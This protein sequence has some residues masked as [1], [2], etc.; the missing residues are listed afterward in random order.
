MAGRH[1]KT[2]RR[3]RHRKPPSPARIAL[4]TGT[5]LAVIVAAVVVFTHTDANGQPLPPLA[6]LPSILLS[7]PPPSV[8]AF[9][10]TKPVVAH[11]HHAVKPAHHHVTP[12]LSWLRRHQS[13]AALRIQARSDCYVQVTNRGGKLLVQRIL[14][15]GDHVAF[16]HH[17]LHV[18]LGN[19]GG[20]R[21]SIDG[22]K[23]RVAG[24]RGSVRRFPVA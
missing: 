11:Q 24:T 7:E 2:T 3:G 8:L 19:A 22:A 10:T 23:P 16:K 5:G 6:S 15:R 14:H 20:V 18:V 17:G 4:P 12:H 9:H 1:R 21:I 13:T